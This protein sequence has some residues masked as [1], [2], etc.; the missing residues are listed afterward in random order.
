MNSIALDI[1]TENPR[2]DPF[3]NSTRI[4]SVQIG[5][6]KSQKVFYADSKES[7]FKLDKVKSEV[8]ALIDKDYLFTG[9]YLKWFDVPL[10]KKFLDVEIP[11]KHYLDLIDPVDSLP[12]AMRRKFQSKR[13]EHVCETLGIKC[14]HK[15]KM[16]AR[17]DTLE[18][19]T[20]RKIEVGQVIMH[21]YNEFVQMNGD[22]KTL[23]Y[24]YAIGDVISEYQLFGKITS[25]LNKVDD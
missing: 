20:Q 5:D 22:K 11:P 21:A 9:Y 17:K 4:I 23:F 25:I 18:R 15:K 10:L 19:E 13:L 24:E 7:E 6:D 14:D 12:Y 16:W 3:I 1:E 2:G 8:D